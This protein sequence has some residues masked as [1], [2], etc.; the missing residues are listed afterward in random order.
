MKKYLTITGIGITVLV[1]VFFTWQFSNQGENITI[2]PVI[3]Q[4]T[5][6]NISG[7]NPDINKEKANNTDLDIQYSSVAAG[8]GDKNVIEISNNKLNFMEKV[9]S[10]IIV[11]DEYYI[12]DEKLNELIVF[13]ESTDYFFLKDK[14]EDEECLDGAYQQM[15]ISIERDESTPSKMEHKVETECRSYTEAKSVSE[16]RIRL[17][18]LI[19]NLNP[20]KT[21]TKFTTDMA[22][23]ER[24]ADCIIADDCCGCVP[25]NKYFKPKVDC[26]VVECVDYDSKDCNA[27]VECIDNVCR[28]WTHIKTFNSQKSCEKECGG[29]CGF[30]VSNGWTCK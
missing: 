16:I 27:K 9:S 22:Y 25:Q 30:W 8:L 19:E 29:E 21:N 23:C 18:E 3:N 28:T 5:E 20:V 14:Y 15:Y 1:S 24:D 26:G 2:P 10:R 6:S 17:Y 13:I 12:S 7:N 4:N 11:D